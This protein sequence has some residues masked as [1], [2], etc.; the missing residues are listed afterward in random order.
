METMF[1]RGVVSLKPATKIFSFR[2][3]LSF[4][5][6][7]CCCGGGG[8]VEPRW[9]TGMHLHCFEVE[10]GIY[11]WRIADCMMQQ[12]PLQK[13]CWIRQHRH[14][15]SWIC[16]VT[17]SQVSELVCLAYL[18]PQN[19]FNWPHWF[20]TLFLRHKT[21]YSVGD[22]SFL[23]NFI[24]VH[25]LRHCWS[26]PAV[27]CDAATARFGHWNDPAVAR[28]S[29]KCRECRERRVLCQGIWMKG[30][31]GSMILS[32]RKKVKGW[33]SSISQTSCSK[34]LHNQSSS[35]IQIAR[36]YHTPWKCD[37]ASCII[38]LLLLVQAMSKQIQTFLRWKIRTAIGFPTTSGLGKSYLQDTASSKNLFTTYK[39]VNVAVFAV[40]FWTNWFANSS[41]CRDTTWDVSK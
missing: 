28:W 12:Q 9:G 2:Q 18:P 3:S 25:T 11:K 27:G 40:Q 39:S 4:F 22:C 16:D 20:L 19:E 33:R 34:S 6:C 15:S 29:R 23:F 21:L 10:L 30:T 17:V 13:R 24:Q 35:E 5:C 26:W 7:G 36:A 1:R 14:S 41:F 31:W 32:S 38:M 8:W 37:H